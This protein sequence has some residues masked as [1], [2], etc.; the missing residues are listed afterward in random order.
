MV[1]KIA[2]ISP[3]PLLRIKGSQSAVVSVV[4][5]VINCGLR[6]S[7]AFHCQKD[8]KIGRDTPTMN[9]HSFALYIIHYN[10]TYIHM[11][12]NVVKLRKE[13]QEGHRR[14]IPKSVQT[15][16]TYSICESIHIPY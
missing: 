5:L 13:N 4:S 1:Q 10:N 15:N 14:K 2:I 9:N 12:N 16:Y 3:T 11:Q 6:R 8:F 7:F